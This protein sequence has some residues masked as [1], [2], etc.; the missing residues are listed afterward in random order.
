MKEKKSRI[1]LPWQSRDQNLNLIV[2]IDTLDH[3][4]GWDRAFA[5][6]SWAALAIPWAAQVAL[7]AVESYFRVNTSTEGDT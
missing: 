3:L 2:T 1:V 4:Q 6:A 5:Q 7:H